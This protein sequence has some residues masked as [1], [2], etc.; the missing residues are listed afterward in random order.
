MMPAKIPTTIGGMGRRSR[1]QLRKSS[2][3]IVM[4]TYPPSAIM[5]SIETSSIKAINAAANKPTRIDARIFPIIF[6]LSRF[7]S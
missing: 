4:G 5:A 2:T 6:P 3:H 7:F 1:P